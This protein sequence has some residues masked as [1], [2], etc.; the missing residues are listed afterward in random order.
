V[1][2]SRS[3]HVEIGKGEGCQEIA[4]QNVALG[5]C[6]SK[7]HAQAEKKKEKCDEGGKGF[8]DV[9]AYNRTEGEGEEDDK[10]NDSA[11]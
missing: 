8:I 9:G 3:V 4:Q 10:K 2:R 5:S 6:G 7:Y 11:D 1:P